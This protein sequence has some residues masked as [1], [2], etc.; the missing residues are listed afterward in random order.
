M[1]AL[2]RASRRRRRAGRRAAIAATVVGLAVVAAPSALALTVGVRVTGARVGRPIPAGFL[3]IAFEYRAIPGMVGSGKPAD[4]DPVAVRLIDNLAPGARPV[5]RI[6]GQSTD[7]TWWPVGGMRRPLGIT[8]DL[9][10]GWMRSARALAEATDAKLILGVGLE[11]NRTRI[12]AVESRRLLAGVGRRYVDTLEIGNEPELYNV[13]AW[14]RKLRGRPIPWFRQD[15]TEVLARPPGFGPA[16]LAAQ[17]AQVLRVLPRVPVAGPATGIPSWL[18]AFRRFVSPRS[19]VRM[20]TWHAYGLNNCVTDPSSPLYPSIPHVVSLAASRDTADGI[21]PYVAL[22]H[23]SGATFR[24]DEMNS[25]TCNG[26]LGISNTMAAALWMTDALFTVAAAGVDGVNIHTYPGA[27][28]R[29]FDFRR[30]H[31]RWQATV[32]PP[33][34]GALLFARAAPVGSRLLRTESGDL[35]RVRSWATLAPDHQVRVLLINDSLTRSVRVLVRTP[36]RGLGSV[37]RLRAPRAGAT[38]G[39]EIGG[40]SFG[41]RTATGLLAAPRQQTVTPRAGAY[42]VTMPAAS[43]A[44]LTLDQR[45]RAAGVTW[46]SV[47][48]FLARFQNAGSLPHHASLL[49]PLELIGFV[50]LLAAAVPLLGLIVTGGRGVL[51]SRRGRRRRMGAAAN[52]EQRARAQMSELCPN[53]WRAQITLFSDGDSDGDEVNRRTPH[54]DPTRVALDWIEL[55]DGSGRPAVM[56]RVWGRTIG[57]AL[58][59]MVADRRTDETLEQIEH[60]AVADGLSWPD[61]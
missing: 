10:P 20:I 1:L 5:L 25:V 51:R 36:W 34:Y 50:I 56:R 53:G 55:R 21:A 8:Y 14:Y 32:R 49:G 46:N 35:A 41:A 59:A 40:E 18:Y 23:R 13:V 43:A 4:V 11:A 39:L 15:G 44:L 48:T 19:R 28:N 31:G 22:A 12:D 16:Q 47:L 26:G 45:A 3:G 27:P 60:R 54:G 57:E 33:Y 29:L 2:L 9:T 24:I 61:L 37:Q 38:T 30:S 7:R 52:A 58:D 6:G 17:F 42:T